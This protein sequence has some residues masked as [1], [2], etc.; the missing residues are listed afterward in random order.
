MSDREEIAGFLSE[1]ELVRDYIELLNHHPEALGKWMQAE[2]DD[3]S[4]WHW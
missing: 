3:V 4:W 2:R 1:N